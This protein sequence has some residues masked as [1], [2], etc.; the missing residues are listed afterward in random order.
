MGTCSKRIFVSNRSK[1]VYD[2]RIYFVQHF[3]GMIWC[4]SFSLQKQSFLP[5]QNWKFSYILTI[6]LFPVVK[7]FN[8]DVSLNE[9]LTRY[10]QEIDRTSLETEHTGQRK[11]VSRSVRVFTVHHF[12]HHTPWWLCI[13]LFSEGKWF[14]WFFVS[15][16][17]VFCSPNV[18]EKYMSKILHNWKRRV[19]TTFTK[20]LKVL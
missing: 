10:I 19:K 8:H 15:S 1:L 13:Q 16:F 14:K 11:A 5:S 4:I 12:L 18:I 7:H 3:Q 2:D 17:L 9:P 6:A 20:L